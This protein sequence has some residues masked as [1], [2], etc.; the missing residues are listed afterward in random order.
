MMYMLIRS[1]EMLCIDAEREFISLFETS[2]LNGS[3]DHLMS[4]K[5]HALIGDEIVKYRKELMLSSLLKALRKFF[6]I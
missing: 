4:D 5:L 2:A 3:E 6:E 1:W